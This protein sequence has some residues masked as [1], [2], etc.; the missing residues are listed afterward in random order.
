MFQQALGQ[1]IPL[2]LAGVSAH[3]GRS[4]PC[5]SSIIPQPRTWSRS[6]NATVG[7]RMT[8]NWARSVFRSSSTGQWIYLSTDTAK[9]PLFQSA[10]LLG[11]R[12]PQPDCWPRRL[13][14]Q[15]KYDKSL[16]GCYKSDHRSIKKDYSGYGEVRA[17]YHHVCPRVW[18]YTL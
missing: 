5:A 12:R 4:P 14:Q 7:R 1:D 13:E 11:I 17:A 9:T 8:A 18:G 10:V 15:L 2:C 16:Q 3:W 6:R